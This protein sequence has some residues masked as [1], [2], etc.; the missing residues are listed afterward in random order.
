[1]NSVLERLSPV[2]FTIAIFVLWEAVCRIFK[3]DRFILHRPAAVLLC[4]PV[5][6]FFRR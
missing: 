4:P 5:D 3:I 6:E 1:M 2:I